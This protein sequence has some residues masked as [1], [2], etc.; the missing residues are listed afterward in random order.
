MAYYRN[1][2]A[3]TPRRPQRPATKH[4]DPVGSPAISATDPN[5]KGANKYIASPEARGKA[6]A[7]ASDPSGAIS[8]A[9]ATIEG[10]WAATDTLQVRTEVQNAAQAGKVPMS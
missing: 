5:K 1:T 4:S 3:P 2:N 7:V 8:C 6:I 10:F 9:S